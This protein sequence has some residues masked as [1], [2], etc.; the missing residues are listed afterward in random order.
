MHQVLMTTDGIRGGREAAYQGLESPS[1]TGRVDYH[2]IDNLRVGL[3]MF[4]GSTDHGSKG[5]DY[6]YLMMMI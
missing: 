3:S 6:H 2:G 4:K 5:S 1:I